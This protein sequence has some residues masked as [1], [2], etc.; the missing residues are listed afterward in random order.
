M[1]AL[2]LAGLLATSPDVSG[3]YRIEAPKVLKLKKGEVA[4]AKVEVVPRSD[5]HVSPDAPISLSL[6]AG[7]GVKRAT[8]KLV[9]GD[10]KEA[11][12]KGDEFDAPFTA[13]SAAKAEAKETVNYFLCTGKLC[14]TLKS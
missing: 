11:E 13:A 9:R 10:A 8:E 3:T 7:P 6:T 14:E 2:A 12:A 1:I 4:H 5:A